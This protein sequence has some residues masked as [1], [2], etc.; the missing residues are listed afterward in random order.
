MKKLLSVIL[1]IVM[2]FTF[3]G[4]TTIVNAQTSFDLVE[5][6][7][8]IRPVGRHAW[9]DNGLYCI[10]TATGFEFSADCEG[11]VSLSLTA[12]CLDTGSLGDWNKDGYL[13]VFIDGVRQNYRVRYM[14]GS[15]TV[16]IAEDIESGVH[17]F[18]VLK[19][20]DFGCK[21]RFKSI[22]MNGTLCDKPASPKYV[23]E[24]VGDSISVGYGS[25]GDNNPTARYS[26][27]TRTWD[28][29]TAQNFGAD[30]HVIAR[31]GGTIGTLYGDYV[32]DWTT[33]AKYDYSLTKPTV[34]LI[35]L[36]GN[37]GTQTVDY[38]KSGIK[39]FTDAI[40]TGYNDVNI[41]IV[42]VTN[43][44]ASAD[45]LRYNMAQAIASLQEDDA[46]A[47]ANIYNIFAD[48]NFN[49]HPI[50]EIHLAAANR[51]TREL[52]E[53]GV[54]SAEDLRDDATITLAKNET[55]ETDIQK[56]D[57]VVN[58]SCAGVTGELVSPLDP[59]NKDSATAKAV[60]YT[61]DGTQAELRGAKVTIGNITNPISD[62]KGISFYI[63]YKDTD[64]IG[65]NGEAYSTP[66]LVIFN[67]DKISEI[68]IPDIKDGETKKVEFYWNTMPDTG[69]GIYV[70]ISSKTMNLGLDFEGACEYIID[71]VKTINCTYLYE[72]NENS[73][74]T[75]EKFYD[76]YPLMGVTGYYAPEDTT[77]YES[78]ALSP[79]DVSNAENW[80]GGWYN[81]GT[82]EYE[83][84]YATRAAVEKLVKVDPACIYGF[85]ILNG[86]NYTIAVREYDSKCRFIN[87]YG[88][89]KSGGT[90]I[91]SA[92]N[93][94]F[95]SVTIYD[96]SNMLN[97]IKDGTISV[98]MQITGEVDNIP[99][100]TIFEYSLCPADSKVTISDSSFDYSSYTDNGRY[101]CVSS[102]SAGQSAILTT[103]SA[104]GTGKYKVTLYMR[105]NSSGR[106]KISVSINNN[107]AVTINSNATFEMYKAY[108]L[109]DS[110][111]ISTGKVSLK[112]E[113]TSSGSIYAGYVTFEKVGEV[114]GEEQTTTTT[115]TTTTVP[116]ESTTTTTTTTV[117]E[118]STTTTTTT[119]VPE[120]ST[121]ITTP[122]GEP[123]FFE[124][125]NCS[126]I[127]PYNG[128]YYSLDFWSSN[129]GGVNYSYVGNNH[130]DLDIKTYFTLKDVPA[131]KYKL[132][133]NSRNATTRGKYIVNALNSDKEL[134]GCF[135]L[136]DFAD[137]TNLLPG[138][139]YQ[140]PNYLPNEVDVQGG[141]V[142]LEIGLDTLG[143][144][145]F[146]IDSFELIK[147][148]NTEVD[149]LTTDLISTDDG[150]SIRLNEVNGMRFYATVDEAVLLELVDGKEY[151]VGTIIAPKD[152]V[153]EYLTIED[154]V[155]KVVYDYA[156]YGL[157]D[158]EYVVGSIVNLKSSNSYN[159]ET[160]NLARDFIARAY[161]LVD[162]VYY[163][164]A[165]TCVRNIAQIAD[166]Y[167]NTS[168]SGY[169]ELDA[170][171]KAMVDLWAKAND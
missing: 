151:E 13:T 138:A 147:V 139:T 9:V 75:Y 93:V 57:S 63:N 67:G 2:L 3:V 21:V 51:V 144:T 128:A 107:A 161:V 104:L 115:T 160:G 120:E 164:S 43:I 145:G 119:T 171:V 133:I 152:T 163:Y 156:T 129:D 28:Y 5:N 118:E 55:A 121:S 54:M 65:A 8:K 96:A 10:W 70:A 95:V 74:Y 39:D 131:G 36:G 99:I 71:N 146:T 166:S 72:S 35:E 73:A 158:G 126:P 114:L 86:S 79:H 90:Y 81:S 116:E 62:A 60:K 40:R 110:I 45:E 15:Y 38:W 109:Y 11:D 14:D 88:G 20:N 132:V 25:L 18:K 68:E 53:I 32:N 154:D 159:T 87:N 91:P 30:A 84:N 77:A 6:K 122:S 170:D 4:T 69:H 105:S 165:S 168:G 169:E 47:Y 103:N 127:C 50:Q 48:T 44:M 162:G 56:F 59:E 24:V 22:N 149:G 46:V 82:G 112:I 123:L 102:A 155:A 1:S 58:T 41:P 31:S 34:V 101:F 124:A 42:M 153:G 157:Y 125:E 97:L 49:Y 136:V 117:P 150:A 113:S 140:T 19:Q 143:T 106:A 89:V 61:A 92:E 27:G 78:V 76:Y 148:T 64:Y 17:T 137:M 135:G 108:S 134:Y 52:I 80:V 85:T 12:S 26:D 23:F 94:K 98:I 141:D 130:L 37:D 100:G 111:D 66:K 83:Q 29:I 16:N 7:D 33:N 142:V 167:I